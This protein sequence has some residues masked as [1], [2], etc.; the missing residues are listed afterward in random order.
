[1]TSSKGE[2]TILKNE[3]IT[4]SGEPAWRLDFIHNYLG[5]QSDYSII[6]YVAKNDK[7][8]EISLITPPLKVEEMRPVG[9]K[10]IQSI[11]FTNNSD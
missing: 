10:I 11:Q 4:F 5:I 9:E 7:L 6:I 1:M 2:P 3:A 8:Y